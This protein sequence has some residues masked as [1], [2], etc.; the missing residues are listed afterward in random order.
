[1]TKKLVPIKS[2]LLFYAKTSINKVFG[3]RGNLFGKFQRNI[4]NVLNELV[5]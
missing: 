5:L 3:C 4:L 2:I 1:M